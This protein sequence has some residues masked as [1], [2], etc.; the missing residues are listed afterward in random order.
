MPRNKS[1]RRGK[2][3]REPS[4]GLRAGW[5]LRAGRSPRGE[6]SA[7]PTGG[8]EEACVA[9]PPRYELR[10]HRPR[11]PQPSRGRRGGNGHPPALTV[12]SEPMLT[13]CAREVSQMLAGWRRSR[14]DSGW[15]ACAAR[16]PAPASRRSSKSASSMS[17][18]EGEHLRMVRARLEGAPVVAQRLHLHRDRQP[19][20]H[21]RR[22]RVH[23]HPRPVPP[24]RLADSAGHL[25]G[26][27][28]GRAAAHGA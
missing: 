10:Q 11:Q 6:R 18:V 8:G 17:Q 21:V 12:N 25:R 13:R 3:T 4:A 26:D 23:D 19:T 27:L 14:A 9:T 24:G 1:S 5:P 2:R 20:P 28:L 16:R 7:G 15:S 22:G